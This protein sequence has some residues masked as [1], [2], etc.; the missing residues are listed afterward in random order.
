MF[1]G[2]DGLGK[3]KAAAAVAYVE[4]DATLFRFEKVRADF[5][6]FVEHG[7]EIDVHVCGDVARAELFGDEI[8]VRTLG[9]KDAEVNHDGYVGEITR[10]KCAIHRGPFGTGEMGSFDADD[11]ARVLLD[12]G[13]RGGGVHVRD[14]LLG[15][16]RPHATADDVEKGD[17]PGERAVDD[18]VLEVGKIF[19]TGAT[20]VGDGGCTTAEGETVWINRVVSIVSAAE[21]GAGVDVDVNVHEAGSNVQAGSVDGTRGTGSRE[22]FFDRDDFVVLDGDVTNFVGVVFCVEDGSTFDE[23][24]VLLLG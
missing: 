1:D 20:G 6:V 4:N 14:V 22:I 10:F 21:S 3:D 19:V 12:D 24:I 23:E 18:A 2:G 15:L 7:D 13:G 16:A 8:G 9:A 5:L 17:D 11:E